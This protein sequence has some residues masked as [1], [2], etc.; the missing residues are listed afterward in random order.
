ME[1]KK[2]AV[3]S[4][5][6]MFYVLDQKGALY[7]VS[8]ERHFQSVPKVDLL[9]KMGEKIIPHTRY[10]RQGSMVAVTSKYVG[11]YNP[12][13]TSEIVGRLSPH[14]PEDTDP[15]DIGETTAPILGLFLSILSALRAVRSFEGYSRAEGWV[16]MFCHEWRDKTIETLRAIGE[17]HPVFVVARYGDESFPFSYYVEANIDQ[18]SK[19]SVP[20][21]LID[22]E[23]PDEM[24]RRMYRKEKKKPGPKKK[25]KAK[26]KPKP[27][28][29]GA[30]THGQRFKKKRPKKSPEA[31]FTPPDPEVLKTIK[32]L[33]DGAI[34][35]IEIFSDRAI[36]NCHDQYGGKRK[37]GAGVHELRVG[38][39]GGRRCYGF[40]S[41]TMSETEFWGNW[42]SSWE[43]FFNLGVGNLV[44]RP[45]LTKPK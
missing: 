10:L 25:S 13:R 23:T 19:P 37:K 34:F 8:S 20:G 39:V 33:P 38:N 9:K 2:M 16:E 43:I 29:K 44:V 6:S 11:L 21:I 12:R 36:I 17:N 24:D 35:W 40:T 4:Q 42:A 30:R 41:E 15:H 22:L 45:H 31:V 1:K 5:L 14:L 18:S 28:Q 26:E 32:S 7:S 3:I 27:I